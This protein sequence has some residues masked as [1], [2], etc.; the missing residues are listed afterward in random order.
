MT[1]SKNDPIPVTLEN[2]RLLASSGALKYASLIYIAS[3]WC[4]SLQ[5]DKGTPTYVLHTERGAPRFFKTIDAGC[6]TAYE[7]GILTIAVM[8]NRY[9]PEQLTI[10]A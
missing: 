6:K 4:L 3:G 1:N 9:K 2:A 8:M 5:S 7:I 10:K